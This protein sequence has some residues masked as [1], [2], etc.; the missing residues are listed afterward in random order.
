ME[1][2]LAVKKRKFTIF[3]ISIWR[4]CAYFIIYSFL[5]Y[6]IE[7]IFGIITMGKWQSRQSFLY[8]PFC[9]IYGL[10]AV[11]FIIPLQRFKDS[12]YRVFLASFIIGSIVE[13]IVSLIGELIFNIKWWDYSNQAFNINGRICVHFSIFWGLLG[14][15]LIS[16]LNP[17]IDRLINFI[18][19]KISFIILKLLLVLTIIFLIVDVILTCYA[20][21]MFTVRIVHE[22]D[23]NV[24]DREKIDRQY[25]EVYVNDKKQAEFILKYFDNEKMIKTFPNIKILDVDGNI[26]YY[27]CYVGDIKTYYYDFNEEK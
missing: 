2:E 12:K 9:G 1:E 3:G 23:L 5:G 7:T 20:L 21:Q 14:I 18:K 26:L 25:E 16:E 15:Y 27:D 11:V 13:Y 10:G 4:I 6:L 19:S 8:G 17:K 22:N 24:E